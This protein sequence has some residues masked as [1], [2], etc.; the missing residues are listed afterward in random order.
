MT[1]SQDAI[2]HLIVQELS[3]PWPSPPYQTGTSFD[4]NAVLFVNCCLHNVLDRSRMTTLIA[5]IVVRQMKEDQLALPGIEQQAITGSNEKVETWEYTNR[6]SVMY[7]P[8]GK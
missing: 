2:G 4:W 8:D 5:I 1:I 3:W 7:I 6:N